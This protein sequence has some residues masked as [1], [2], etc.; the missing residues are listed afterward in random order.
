M[1]MRHAR[2]LIPALLIPLAAVVPASGQESETPPTVIESAEASPD[3]SGFTVTADVDW[4]GTAPVVLGT[5]PTGDAPPAGNAT[6]AQGL[7][8]TA[9]S[10]WI[11]DGDELEATFAFDLATFDNPPPPEIVRYYMTFM[12][13]GQAFALQAKTSDFVSG[14]NLSDDPATLAENIGSYAEHISETS[15]LP[16]FRVRGN[17]GTVGVVN[18]CGH[19]AW[20][21]GEF[22]TAGDQVRIDV[23]LDLE[24]LP[25]LRPGAS[26]DPDQGAW[27]SLQAGADFAQTRDTL[28][29][30][31]QEGLPHQ[32]PRRTST[33]TLRDSAGAVVAGPVT[34]SVADDGGVQGQVSSAGLAAGD[35]ELVVSACI[36][37]N[38]GTTSIPVTI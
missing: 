37:A 4:G 5:D 18:N 8:L 2:A 25:I 24:D 34:L 31:A 19:V 10:T 30:G 22:D 6:A 9:V 38:C 13:G 28:A 7:D 16:Q 1:H 21:S 32:I 26:L 11:E 12:I 14:A 29:A 15:T 3:G 33:A 36:A 17:C 27:A 23:P 35:Y 20:V